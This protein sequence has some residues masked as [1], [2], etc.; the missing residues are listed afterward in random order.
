MCP[1]Q[2]PTPY[3]QRDT[4]LV[5]LERGGSLPE[6]EGCVKDLCASGG[7]SDGTKTSQLFPL[8]PAE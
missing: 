6:C 4:G 1:L 2:L 8:R 7:A 5:L 3:L